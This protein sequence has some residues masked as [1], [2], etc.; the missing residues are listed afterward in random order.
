[1]IVPGEIDFE[2]H[3]ADPNWGRV[4]AAM[5]RSGVKF[6]PSKVKIWLGDML[7]CEHGKEKTFSEPAAIHYLENKKIVIRV[8]LG[9]GHQSARYKTCDFT[10]QYVGI[11]AGYRT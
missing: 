11:N 1:L 8:A 6:D 2:G 3:G 4:L 5:G 10:G 9:L 7:V